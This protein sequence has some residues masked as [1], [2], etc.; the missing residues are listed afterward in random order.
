MTKEISTFSMF[1]EL[2]EVNREPQGFHDKN[3]DVNNGL[4]STMEDI[5]KNSSIYAVAKIGQSRNNFRRIMWLLV[6]IIGFLGC[7]LQVYRFF[8][9]YFKYPIIVNL[10]SQNSIDI[11]YL[12]NM[13]AHNLSEDMLFDRNYS[14]ISVNESEELDVQI[15]NLLG[16]V[17]SMVNTVPPNTLNAFKA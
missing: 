13:Q 5:F 4:K 1:K 12:D 11:K 6:L 7:G 3:G 15:K 14:K 17:R 16:T 9:L 8:N 2:D 10:E